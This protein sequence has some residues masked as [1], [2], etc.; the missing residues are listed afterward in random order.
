MKVKLN[1]VAV[2]TAALGVVM[3]QKM[4]VTRALKFR[5]ILK[6]VEEV[7]TIFNERRTAIADKYDLKDE[8]GTGAKIPEELREVV[9]K[10]LKE[11]ANEEIELDCKYVTIED[12]KDI[13]LSPMDLEGIFFLIKE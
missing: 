12:L 3:N 1:Q 8:D 11:L 10:E 7:N 6:E 2:S 9:G 13:E 4:N 5:K